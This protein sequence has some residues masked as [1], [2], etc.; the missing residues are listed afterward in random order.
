[1]QKAKRYSKSNRHI[2]CC[3]C[4]GTKIAIYEELSIENEFVST[5]EDTKQMVVYLDI[6]PVIFFTHKRHPSIHEQTKSRIY[7]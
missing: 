1:M 3:R 4:T 2:N 7:L 6:E 5:L